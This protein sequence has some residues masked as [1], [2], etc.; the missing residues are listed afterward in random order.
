MCCLN[1]INYHVNDV[2]KTAQRCGRSACI[3]DVHSML[4]GCVWQRSVE[5]ECILFFFVYESLSKKA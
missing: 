2:A 1:D 5:T 4:Q 3:P